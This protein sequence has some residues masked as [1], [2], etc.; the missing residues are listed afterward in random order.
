[1]QTPRRRGLSVKG[2]EIAKEMEDMRKGVITLIKKLDGSPA[3]EKD[4]AQVASGSTKALQTLLKN[5]FNFYNGYDPMFSW[6][7]P[8]TYY[9]LDSV[10]GVYAT[11]LSKK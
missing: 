11:A 4:Q 1:M 7:V 10:L 8:K 5:Y 3:L 9:A 2:E 6:W